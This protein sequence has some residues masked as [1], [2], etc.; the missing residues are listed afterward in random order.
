[1][2]ATLQKETVLVADDC[3]DMLRMISKNLGDAGIRVIEARDGAEALE[4]ARTLLPSLAVL[5]LKMPQL[6]GIEVLK[7]LKA[8]SATANI[9]VVMLTA[10]GDE[11]DRI[12]AFELGTDDYLSKPFSPRELVL[13][14]RGILSRNRQPT[15]PAF[16]QAGPIQIDAE[17]YEVYVCERRLDVTATE[18]RLLSILLRKAGRVFTRT[19]LVTETWGP[20]S[21]VDPRN[22]DTHLRRLRAKMGPEADLIQT[23]R[24]VGYRMTG[25]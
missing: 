1:M 11:V 16:L 4:K 13:R 22:V 23:I 8:G 24:G 9:S 6:S 12:L 20:E 15:D 18:F 17:R 25:E 19:E 7:A 3:P 10:H 14:V 5:D 21:D 2:R